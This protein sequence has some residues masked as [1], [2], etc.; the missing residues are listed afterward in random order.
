[1]TSRILMGEVE[2]WREWDDLLKGPG[3]L[4]LRE[5]HGVPVGFFQCFRASCLDKVS[6]LELDHFEGADMQF[7]VQMLAHFGREKRLIGMPVLHLDHG[8]SQWYGTQKH[9]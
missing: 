3:E 4:R 9:L 2:P 7:G 1:V 5:S 6:Y 8:G